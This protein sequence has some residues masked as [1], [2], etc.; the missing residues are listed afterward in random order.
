MKA[1][2]F[3]I[4]RKVLNIKKTIAFLGLIIALT[5]CEDLKDIWLIYQFRPHHG[6]DVE[7]KSGKELYGRCVSSDA[8]IY[9][10]IDER[11]DD[12]LVDK[13]LQN[14]IYKKDGVLQ[15]NLLYDATCL[16]CFFCS[17]IEDMEPLE[18]GTV[19]F[20]TICYIEDIYSVYNGK[21]ERVPVWVYS[22]TLEDLCRYN[23]V[24]PFPDES[25][26]INIRQCEY[27]V[28]EK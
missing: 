3:L 28:K 17:R 23:W 4:I 15:L 7:N 19:L 2:N 22:Y 5:G 14:T 11:E 20:L 10:N 18:D 27:T 16:N 6:I 24:V 8:Y 25:G 26:T 13:V 21:K 1:N 12:Y 9:L